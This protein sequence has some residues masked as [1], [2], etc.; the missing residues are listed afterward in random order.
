MSN[1][2]KTLFA[3]I[4]IVFVSACD[5]G[6]DEA[7]TTSLVGTWTAVSFSADVQSTTTFSGNSITSSSVITGSD[8]NYDVTFTET[9]FTTSGSYTQNSTISVT[10]Q[11]EQTIISEVTGV[12]GSGSYTTTAEEITLNGSFYDLEL[13]GMPVQAE[14]Q[15]QTASYEIN[16]NGELIFSQNETITLSESG[17]T[18]TVSIVSTS[19]WTRK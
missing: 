5:S 17:V 4:I 19:R 8:F 9:A 1:R 2:I 10:G 16:S 3:L 12:S 15:E 6:G 13:N 11:A 18:S 7:P 14:G